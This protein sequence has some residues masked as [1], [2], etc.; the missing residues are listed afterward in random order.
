[1]PVAHVLDGGLGQR[2]HLDEPLRARHRLDRR[3]AAVARADIMI[4]RLGLDEVALLL[5]IGQ[6]GLA[7]LVAVEAVVLAA[8]DDTG[9]LVED[10]D[11]LEIMAQADLVSR[12][13][14]G[15]ASS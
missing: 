6:N 3:A 10:E 15:R 9:V 11:L 13:G 14:R 4:I 5:E 12:S 7:R 1:M 2:L 8:V